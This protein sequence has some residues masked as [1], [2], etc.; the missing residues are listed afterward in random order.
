MSENVVGNHALP[1]GQTGSDLAFSRLTTWFQTCSNQHVKYGAKN[2][3]SLPHRVLFVGNQAETTIQLVEDATSTAP[4]VCLSHRWGPDTGKVCLGKSNLNNFKAGILVTSLPQ[5]FQDVIIVVWRLGL[6]YLWID[7]LCIIQDDSRDWHQ[8][9]ASMASIYENAFITIAATWYHGDNRSLFSSI[10]PL[11]K[12]VEIGKIASHCVLLR[13]EL[14]HPTTR[15]F[16]S[17]RFDYPITPEFPLF[18]RGWVFQER[19]LSK[20]IIY[21]TE[22]EICW[23]CMENNWCECLA[24]ESGLKRRGT[25]GDVSQMEWHSI[26]EQYTS[27]DLSFHKD[28]LPAISGVA[29]R[30]G[31]ARGWHYLA[32]LWME[33]LRSDLLWIV[34]DQFTRKPRPTPLVAPT[35]SWAS[36]NSEV[37]W[38]YQVDACSF[39]RFLQY[40]ISPAG[41]DTYGELKFA[42]LKIS[43]FVV[44]ATIHYG[45]DWRDIK[46]RS[47]AHPRDPYGKCPDEFLGAHGE[48][49]LLV[50]SRSYFFLFGSSLDYMVQGPGSGYIESGSEVILLILG[51]TRHINYSLRRL[52]HV[53]QWS[54]RLALCLM[55]R[56]IDKERCYYERIGTFEQSRKIV[57]SDWLKNLAMRTDL[58]LC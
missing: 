9:A 28:R 18:T 23:E 50:G 22:N 24:Q 49:G 27:L 40:S 47:L 15:F 52:E 5:L 21:F 2:N 43:G 13:P 7:S 29:K 32:G 11:Y 1:S 30:I 26:I 33:S 53:D 39:V 6:K 51:T 17:G 14:P 16:S 45:L 10:L 3:R 12:S 35:W 58:N 31:G 37:G 48:L 57:F 46:S 56:C 38:H 19:L 41:S 36:V 54:G 8:E 25:D 4:Y 42:Q 55:L 44:S 20:R 34:R